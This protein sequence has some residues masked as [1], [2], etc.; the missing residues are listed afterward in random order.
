MQ[1]P[2]ELDDRKDPC[3][4]RV[5]SHVVVVE[6]CVTLAVESLLKLCFGDKSSPASLK[7]AQDIFRNM[8]MI[9]SVFEL[10]VPVRALGLRQ[11]LLAVVVRAP[12]EEARL[13]V[14]E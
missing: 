11:V 6:R 14:A 7:S 13:S 1:T 5:W 4:P 12:V 8:G 10:V 9:E 3:M 2:V